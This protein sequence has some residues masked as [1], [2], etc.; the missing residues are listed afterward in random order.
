MGT[1]GCSGGVTFSV[2]QSKYLVQ[3]GNS[4]VPGNK[5]DHLSRMATRSENE[6]KKRLLVNKV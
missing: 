6:K 1:I 5:G 4:C 3:E 2:I